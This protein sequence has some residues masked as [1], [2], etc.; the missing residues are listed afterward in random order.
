MANVGIDNPSVLD[1]VR[2]RVDL[3]DEPDEF[4]ASSCVAIATADFRL[5]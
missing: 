1:L 3:Y 5:R 4:I 2:I